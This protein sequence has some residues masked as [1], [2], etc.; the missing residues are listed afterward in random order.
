VIGMLAA[1]FLACTAALAWGALWLPP[2]V[3]LLGIA[4]AG[5]LWSWRRAVDALRHA[6]P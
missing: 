5:V 6:P 2:A 4:T 3:P 1:T